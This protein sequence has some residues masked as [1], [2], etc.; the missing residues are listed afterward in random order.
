M[1]TVPIDNERVEMQVEL[2]LKRFVEQSPIQLDSNAY[3]ERQAQLESNARSYPRSFPIAMNRACGVYVEDTQGQLFI[4]CLAGAGTLALGHNHPAI[5]NVL[6]AYLQSGSPLHTLDITTPTK[7]A[8]MQQLFGI[9]PKEMAGRA[10]VQF[11]G[12]T[13]ADAVEA[14]VKLAKT[15][16]GKSTVLVFDGAYHGM[17]HGTLAMMGNL[18]TKSPV[19]SLMPDVQFLP[20]PNLYRCPFGLQ[21]EDSVRA[22]LHQLENIL[23]NPQSGVLPPAAVVIEAI[24]GEGGVITAPVAWLKGLREITA[25]FDIPLIFDEVQSG[26]GR[27]GKMFAFEHADIVPDMIVMS[28]AVGGGLPLAVVAYD[29]RWDKWAPGAHTGTFRGNQMAMAAGTVILKTITEQDLPGHAAKMGRRLTAY[30]KALQQDCPYIGEVRGKGLMLGVEIVDADQGAGRFVSGADVPPAPFGQLADAIK[31]LCLEN[32]LIIESGGR[33]GS[34]LRFL[35]P[36]TISAQEID[37]VS[38]I[39]SHS[40]MQAVSRLQAASDVQADM[41]VS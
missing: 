30:L 33:D 27:S 41:A 9:L 32:G 12:P 4:D 16:T 23:S 40:V 18:G 3:L 15:A 14:A 6:H 26:I 25:K 22:N 17:T 1:F 36:L 11:C 21:G 29:E 19:K 38:E 7:D 37:K 34:T 31:R 10:K 28:K 39:F 24:Q 13:G 2:N 20:Y 35:P 5:H 8:F